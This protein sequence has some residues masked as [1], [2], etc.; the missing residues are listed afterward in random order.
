MVQLQEVCTAIVDCEH[1]TAPTQDSGY[2]SIRTPNIGRGFFILDNV[3]RVSEATY[4]AWTQR[5]V[6][7]PGDLIM[8]REA[9]V[10]NVARI[11]EGLQPC[12]GQRT[13]LIRP[14]HDQIDAAYLTYLLIGPQVQGS[15]HAQ[16][17]G[18]TV[19]HLNMKDVRQLEL[20]GLPSRS[21]QCRIAAILSAYDDL[22]ENCE[23]RIRLLD[24]MARAL[25][26]EWFL[27]FRY[28]GHEGV[29]S[30]ESALGPI[31]KGWAVQTPKQI[32]EVT[33]G[34]PFQSSLFSS[35][36][37]GTPV[38]RIRDIPTGQSQTY[39]TQSVDS[40]Y[41]LKNGDI[42]VGMDGDFHTSIW[43]NGFAFQNQRVAR[44][45]PIKTWAPLHFLL[46]LEPSIQALNKSIVGTTVAHLGDMHIKQIAILTPNASVLE[47][48]R[49]QFRAIGD[50]IVAL[51]RT[52]RLLRK[53]R[54]LLIPRLL[55]GELSVEDAA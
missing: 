18:A 36:P 27:L 2:P 14:D 24:S 39:T 55:S 10:G 6:P 42:L 12:L 46:A 13:L 29:P 51:R 33:Y 40:R 49:R 54:D 9:P 47:M 31:P 50:E 8:A 19:A 30:V 35:G 28:P 22:I 38:V 4:R 44:F 15:I 37:V 20:P 26:R 45:E 1:K 17:N 52:S 11:P 41:H 32:A 7:Q 53:T 16:T 21:L 5:A 3:N 25:Y 34:Y 43:S 48:A 23:R